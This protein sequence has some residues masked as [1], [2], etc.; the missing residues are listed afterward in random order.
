MTDTVRPDYLEYYQFNGEVLSS[1]GDF[2]GDGLNDL[3]V[4]Q[5]DLYFVSA[6]DLAAADIA[7]GIQDGMIELDNVDALPDST[8]WYVG[9]NG[10]YR[11]AIITDDFNRDGKDDLAVS[12]N[13]YFGGVSTT[14]YFDIAREEQISIFSNEDRELGT[15]LVTLP[16]TN[17]DGI[18][19]LLVSAANTDFSKV[20]NSYLI[21]SSAVAENVVSKKIDLSDMAGLAASYKFARVYTP[22]IEDFDD[23]GFFDFRSGDVLAL[24]DQLQTDNVFR[25]VDALDGTQDNI[26]DVNTVPALTPETPTI[27]IG[28]DAGETIQGLSGSDVIL[29]VAGADSLSGGTGEDWVNAGAGADTLYGNTGFDT[30]YGMSGE[31]YLSGYTGADYLSG[32]KGADTLEAGSGNDEVYGNTG[33]D[34]LAGGRGADYVSGASGADEIYGNSGLDTLV[35]GSGLDTLSGGAGSD[36]LDGGVGSDVLR[37]GG[38]RDTFVFRKGYNRD[39][40]KDFE[41]NV[42]TI[43]LN[44]DLWSGTLSVFQVI[45]LYAS[46]RGGSVVFDF[47]SDELKLEGFNSLSALADDL[48]IV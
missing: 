8:R 38:D 1:G 41:N 25:T 15:G 20:P 19:D 48:V 24:S 16:D 5:F 2:D 23:D 9:D 7:D 13:G 18:D 3:I 47:G 29:G 40:I 14:I 43:R 36:M 37:G 44:D 45:D 26:I 34:Y 11:N 46:V 28:T 42:D 21:S 22:E 30:L 17:G 10:G 35:G 27:T 12:L 31:D 6:T 33:Y 32:G 4:G 39:V